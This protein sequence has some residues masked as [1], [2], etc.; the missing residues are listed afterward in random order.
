MTPTPPSPTPTHMRREIDAIPEAVARLL[1]CS[2]AAIAHTAD[3]LRRLDPPAVVTIARG[4]SDHAALF[5]KYAVQQILGRPVASI[6][7]SLASVYGV[8]PK[9]GGMAAIAISQSGRS[10]DIVAM[11]H[12]AGDGGANTIALVN[13]LPSPLAEAC[14]GAIDIQAGPEL[15]VAATKSFVCSIAAGL[16][17]LGHWSGDIALRRAVATLPSALERALACDWSDFRAASERPESVY[18]LGRGPVAAIAQ[19]AALKFKETCGIH[20]EAYS[21]AEVLHGPVELVAQ[22]FPVLAL[23][24][25]DAAA[26]SVASVA[27]DLAAKGASVFTTAADAQQANRLMLAETGHP[28]TDALACVV[29]FYGLVEAWSRALGRAPDTPRSLAKVTETT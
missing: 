26:A 27:D 24:V 22:R 9:L 20:A 10:P 4:S 18:V 17:V 6:G 13:V 21:S 29:P 12:A 11:A 2:G 25:S 28:L 3:M 16:A 1:D 19:E 23:A 8:T 5:L 15:S 14:H 7:P